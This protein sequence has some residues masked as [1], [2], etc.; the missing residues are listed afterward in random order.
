MGR[1]NKTIS[2]AFTT[3][4]GNDK[5][6]SA[7]DV[8]IEHGEK[9]NNGSV[10]LNGY[11]SEYSKLIEKNKEFFEKLARL[12]VVIMQLRSQETTPEIKLSLV[13]DHIYARS[14]FY[15]NN[16]TANDIRVIVGKTDVWGSDLN[17][18]MSNKKFMNKAIAKLDKA[19]ETEI[20]SNIH[21]L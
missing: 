7:Y 19:M 21:N 1:V 20:Q 17:K 9:Q 8:F 16:S 10:E 18:L 5:E 13:R 2:G 15:R 11:V 14:P 3:I 6:K 12:E 4:V